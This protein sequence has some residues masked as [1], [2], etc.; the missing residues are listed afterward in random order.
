MA[1]AGVL[2]MA[3]TDIAQV[4][5]ADFI[6]DGRWALRSEA[7]IQARIADIIAC[8]IA[9]LTPPA[10]EVTPTLPIADQDDAAC[11]AVH[12]K[13]TA[14]FT[15][16]RSELFDTIEQQAKTIVE[17]DAFKANTLSGAGAQSPDAAPTSETNTPNGETQAATPETQAATPDAVQ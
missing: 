8:Q 16:E 10:A 13:L 17:L 15:Q 5:Y 14:I 4:I 1:T 6:R 12:E 2:I 11:Q 7:E 3:S 9:S